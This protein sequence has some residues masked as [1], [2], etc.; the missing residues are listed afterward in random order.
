M[1]EIS[2][3]EGAGAE[4]AAGGLLAPIG[5]SSVDGTAD[6]DICV[7]RAFIGAAGA[8]AGGCAC[9]S[10]L[11][12]WSGKVVFGSWVIGAGSGDSRMT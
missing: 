7:A 4:T 9:G 5:D 11:S 10:G 3:S 6:G 1:P 8:L 2:S 12:G